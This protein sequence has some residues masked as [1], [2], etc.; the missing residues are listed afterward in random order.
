MKYKSISLLA[1]N[2]RLLQVFN[3]KVTQITIYV[4]LS[5]ISLSLISFVHFLCLNF[6]RMTQNELM[7]DVYCDV[8]NQK[9]KK[10]TLRMVV[11]MK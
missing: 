2:T 10:L 9:R 3:T 7:G 8:I 6:L 11:L 4:F 5:Y 1:Y